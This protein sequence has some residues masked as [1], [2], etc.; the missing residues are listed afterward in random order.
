MTPRRLGS[1][2]AALVW[3]IAIVV[4]APLSAQ[5]VEQRIADPALEAR[6]GALHKQLRG[7]VCQNQSIVNSRADL[8]RDLRIVVRERIEAGDTDRQVLD[9]M[10]ARYGDWVLMKPPFKMTTL[11]LWLGPGLIFVLAAGGVFVALRRGGRLVAANAAPLSDEE[12]DRLE[13]I[14][15]ETPEGGR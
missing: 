13:D 7:L 6:A 11:L 10:V 3:L 15:G 5:F 1:A 9:Y 2:L 4:A 8:A 14:L 12:R